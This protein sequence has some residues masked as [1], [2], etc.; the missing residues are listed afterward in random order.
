M[1]RVRAD[2]EEIVEQYG[3]DGRLSSER[4]ALAEFGVWDR[5]TPGVLLGMALCLAVAEDPAFAREIAESGDTVLAGLISGDFRAIELGVEDA[6]M[7]WEQVVARLVEFVRRPDA[8][9]STLDVLLSQ[10]EDLW[11]EVLD[12]GEM[13][14]PQVRDGE[15]GPWD[16]TETPVPSGVE[17][18][19]YG[20]LRVPQL[21][22]ARIH[23][24]NSGG[25]AV[26]VIV[27]LGDHALSLQAFRVPVGPVWGKVRPKIIQG[28]RNQGG[29]A[30]DA[31]SSLGSEVRARIPVVKG[32]EQV[33]QPTRIVGCDGPGWL[34]RGSYGGPAALTDVVDP[35]FYH[36]FTQTIVDL[37]P[38]TAE[39]TAEV[40]EVEVTM[41]SA[42]TARV[43]KPEG[44]PAGPAVYPRDASV[45]E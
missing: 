36:L 6:A 20:V 32:G 37:P 11:S 28:V 45:D 30:E 1:N 13:T 9:A 5:L 27:S 7:S 17:R 22:G 41:P 25:R 43:S 44:N 26:G 34:L 40:A 38:P 4:L 21:E 23:P 24:L 35:R 42:D 39:D 18:L 29:T 14:R 2:V 15:F 3:R 31:E 8:S 10:A 19:D 12:S 16:E 33:L